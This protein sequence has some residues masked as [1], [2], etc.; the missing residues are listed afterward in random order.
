MHQGFIEKVQGLESQVRALEVERSELLLKSDSL[1]KQSAALEEE[2]ERYKATG[3]MQGEEISRL[4]RSQQL[5]GQPEVNV[6]QQ[7]VKRVSEKLNELH[8]NYLEKERE[9]DVIRREAEITKESLTRQLEDQMREIEELKQ[10]RD[11]FQQEANLLKQELDSLRA[12][13]QQIEPEPDLLRQEIVLRLERE[14][15]RLRDDN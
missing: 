12:G 10:V 14:N 8:L 15:Q 1:T 4:T 13:G 3:D 5:H 6:S 11:I 7:S 2:L 9:L